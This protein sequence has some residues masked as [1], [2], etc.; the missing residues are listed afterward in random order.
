MESGFVCQGDFAAGSIFL[1]TNTE[2]DFI[3]T[4][5]LEEAF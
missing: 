3:V 1:L 5:N 4:E 2:I